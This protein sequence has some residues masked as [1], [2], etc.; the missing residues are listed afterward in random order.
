MRMLLRAFGSDFDSFCL[1]SILCRLIY[2]LSGNISSY[3][4]HGHKSTDCPEPGLA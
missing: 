1:F 4:Q 3:V 2:N